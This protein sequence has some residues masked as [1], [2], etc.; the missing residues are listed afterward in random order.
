MILTTMQ[1]AKLTINA[2]AFR[3][4]AYREEIKLVERNHRRRIEAEMGK[5]GFTFS[6][7]ADRHGYTVH[8]RKGVH[9]S[10]VDAA[11]FLTMEEARRI[12]AKN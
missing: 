8:T 4:P 5:A 7:D 1:A 2:K 6:Y 3:F 12:F 10:F 9:P 11:G